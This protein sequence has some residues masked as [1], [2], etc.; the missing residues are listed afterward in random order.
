MLLV[1]VLAAARHHAKRLNLASTRTIKFFKL[2]MFNFCSVLS[3][4][5]WCQNSWVYYPRYRTIHVSLHVQ[6]RRAICIALILKI[7]T[8]HKFSLQQ[9][10][11]QKGRYLPEQNYL[12]QTEKN[13][14]G[15]DV[16]ISHLQYFLLVE[17]KNI[18]IK[19]HWPVKFFLLI[20]VEILCSTH[21]HNDKLKMAVF[22]L[23]SD[24]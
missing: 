18:I 24:C 15:I 7:L 20:K 6:A 4:Y 21:F 16:K 10:N 13:S 2:R 17:I 3:L 23:Y 22:I 19:Y 1:R 8:Q 14:A 5:V 11:T 12:H 9:P